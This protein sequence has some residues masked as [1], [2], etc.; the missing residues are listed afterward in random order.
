LCISFGLSLLL[1]RVFERGRHAALHA[2]HAGCIV[3]SNVLKITSKK[4]E[5]MLARAQIFFNSL[6]NNF[7][8]NVQIIIK[9]VILHLDYVLTLRDSSELRN[10]LNGQRG[11][12]R[13][14]C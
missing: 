7:E 11:D 10:R 1:Y 8:N 6:T 14:A 3:F 4:V 5:E 9:P 13:G 12:S 2:R